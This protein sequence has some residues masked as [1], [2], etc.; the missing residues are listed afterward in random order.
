LEKHIFD[1]ISKSKALQFAVLFIYS[2]YMKAIILCAG[3]GTRLQ[4][5]TDTIPKTLLD[6]KGKPIL[7]YILENLPD[8]IDEVFIIVD[9]LKENIIDFIARYNSDIKMQCVQQFHEK[10]GTLAALFSVKDFLEPG[11]RFLVLNGDDLV[12]K[13]DLEKMLS[14][15]RSFGIQKMIMPNYYKVIENKGLL[16]SF[17][18]QNE[19]EKK[20]GVFIA[21][22]TYLLDTEI[23][24]FPYKLLKGDEIGIPQTILE[25]KKIYP[26]NLVEFS[27][28][29]PINTIQDLGNINNK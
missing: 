16:D 3:R 4:P 2:K 28:W 26:I 21:T 18:T 1:F 27:T 19:Q 25:Q 20:E 29:T 7:Q 12:S 22:G 5:L 8:Q 6:I 15:N 23:F 17:E 24:N 13:V 14:H 11:E 10:K 9:Y